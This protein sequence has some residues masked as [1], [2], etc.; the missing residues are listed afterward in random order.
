MRAWK[1]YVVIFFAVA[2]VIYLFVASPFFWYKT[3]ILGDQ[4]FHQILWKIKGSE[5]YEIKTKLIDL[6]PLS[7]T[8][9]VTVKNGGITK[10]DATES[11]Y[12]EASHDM[13][14]RLTI[15]GMFDK[16]NTC[17]SEYPRLI[18]SFKYDS[19][20]GFPIWVNVDCPNEDT[21]YDSYE[22]IEV[23]YVKVWK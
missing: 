19:D 15:D 16:V 14:E 1:K 11:K 20:Y 3:R 13:Y 21:C 23:V 8:N 18:C 4:V 5:N 22:T 17:I 2:L 12:G 9:I 7:G 10:V 6:T